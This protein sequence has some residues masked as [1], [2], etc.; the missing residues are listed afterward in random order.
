MVDGQGADAWLAAAERRD[1]SWWNDWHTWQSR[2][3]GG[4]K[5]PARVPGAGAL[6]PI[7]DA[8]GSYVLAS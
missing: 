8:P 6:T 1:G 4:K 2:R 7:E 5:V 3:T